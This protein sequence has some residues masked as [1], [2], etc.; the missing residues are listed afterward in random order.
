MKTKIGR[1]EIRLERP[2][3]RFE[4]IVYLDGQLVNVWRYESYAEAFRQYA[5]VSTALGSVDTLI[6][7]TPGM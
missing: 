2:G 3:R 6:P 1:H 5:A 7:L 4:V